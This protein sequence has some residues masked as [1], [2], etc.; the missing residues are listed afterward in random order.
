M[1]WYLSKT[2]TKKTFLVNVIF[3]SLIWS[4]HQNHLQNIQNYLKTNEKRKIPNGRKICPSPN[5]Q[6][7]IYDDVE[8]SK[9]EERKKKHLTRKDRFGFCW[10]SLRSHHQCL[11]FLCPILHEL[12][13]DDDDDP[14]SQSTHSQRRLLY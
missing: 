2:N 8:K 12:S 9:R 5:K 11:S 13:L 7:N 3:H 6:D 1:H 4:K 14:K 10:E